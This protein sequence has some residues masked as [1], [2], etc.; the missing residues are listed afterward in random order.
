MKKQEKERILG[1]GICILAL[2]TFL[3]TPIRTRPVNTEPLTVVL[4]PGHGGA[5]GGAIGDDGTLEKDLNLKRAKN[6]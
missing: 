3:V 1:I 6:I 5:D 4:D 2:T